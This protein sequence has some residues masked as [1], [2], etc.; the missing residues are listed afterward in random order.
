MFVQSALKRKSIR[1]FS[2]ERFSDGLKSEIADIIRGLIPLYGDAVTNFKFCPAALIRDDLSGK[3]VKAPYYIIISARRDDGYLENAG[4]MAE[5]LVIEMTARGIATC[6]SGMA[7]PRNEFSVKG[8]YCITLALGYPSE[9][10]SFRSDESEFKR[11]P[12]A[13]MLTGNAENDFLEPFICCA[14]LAPSAMN[15]QPVVYELHSNTID[16]YRKKPITAYFDKLQRIDTGIAV[17]HIFMYAKECGFHIDTYKKGISEKDK[18]I[19]FLSLD[20]MEETEDE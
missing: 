5:Q 17:S 12:L 16:V 4:F 11:I 3:L 20:I 9:K 15:K 2:K 6:Y 18:L 8:E 1:D 14:R 7:K 19:Y 10:E 13:K